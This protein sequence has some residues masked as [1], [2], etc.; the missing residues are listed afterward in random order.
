[1]EWRGR[2][3]SNPSRRLGV[4]KD[5]QTVCEPSLEGPLE[6]LQMQCVWRGR[7]WWPVYCLVGRIYFIPFDRIGVWY[8]RDYI[9]GCVLLQ[10]L[11]SRPNFLL[12]MLQIIDSCWHGITGVF[13][14]WKRYQC[15]L[16]CL[17]SYQFIVSFIYMEIHATTITYSALNWWCC[18]QWCNSFCQ[19]FM[20]LRLCWALL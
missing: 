5:R 11:G 4:V 8:Y 18:V 15:S 9:V 6:F 17:N 3:G 10:A 14:A 16:A 12:Q 20:T 13:S 7:E 2:N 1:M 19:L